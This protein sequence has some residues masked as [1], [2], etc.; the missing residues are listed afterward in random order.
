MGILLSAQIENVSTRKDRTLKVV[1]GSQ[2][3]PA[4]KSGE[5]ISLQNNLCHVYISDKPIESA[6]IVEID[7]VSIDILQ[8]EKSPSKRLKSVFYLLWKQNNEGY[9]DSELYYRYKMEQ[10]IDFYKNKIQD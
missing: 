5:I 3:L 9:K 8:D 6:M 7:K 2:E 1:I 4:N 10:V